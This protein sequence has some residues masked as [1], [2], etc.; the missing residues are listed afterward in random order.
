MNYLLVNYHFFCFYFFLI[1][2]F[3][4]FYFTILYWFC[5]TLTWIHH[6]CTG[7]PKHEPPSH[8]PPHIISLDHSRAPATSIRYPASN[9]DWQFVSH[10]I[11]HMF[12]CHSPKSFHPLPLPQSPKV[13]STH[14]CLF[15]YLAYSQCG[16]SLK[17]S[18]AFSKTSLN[19]WKFMVHV[20]LKPGLENFEL[21]FTSMW[22]E[23][24]CVV[25]WAFFGI[26]FLWD[27]N[28]NWPFPVRGHCWVFHICFFIECST[29]TAS[30]F[31]IWNTQLEFH[32]L[33]QLCS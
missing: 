11:L 32:H 19:I 5:H 16:D 26:S 30:S 12:Q 9:I 25:V 21:Y 15:C 29:F 8:L 2:I 14:L 18:S 31:R 22:H 20:F 13:C 10:M 33:H 24:N 7:V 28:E 3:T 1:F 6:R 23:C 17:N 27:W 4:L